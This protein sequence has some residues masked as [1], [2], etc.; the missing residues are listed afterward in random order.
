MIEGLEL[1]FDEHI[2]NISHSNDHLSISLIV[3]HSSTLM[4]EP[5]GS[6]SSSSSSKYLS[7]KNYKYFMRHS[8]HPF[9]DRGIK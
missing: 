8:V 7:A 3:F 5:C 1:G 2:I 9:G 4:E 6:L